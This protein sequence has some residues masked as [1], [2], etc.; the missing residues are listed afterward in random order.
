MRCGG[1]FVRITAH[2]ARPNILVYRMVGRMATPA[3][4]VRWEMGCQKPRRL[5]NPVSL[6]PVISINFSRLLT[7]RTISIARLARWRRAANSDTSASFAAPS[8]GGAVS[9]TRKVLPSR[10]ISSRPARGVTRTA[11]RSRDG[12]SADV[13]Q[14]FIL[15]QLYQFA[16]SAERIRPS[17]C[18][19]TH[20]LKMSAT[21]RLRSTIMK[22]ARGIRR[23]I[24]WRM[25]AVSLSKK[26]EMRP[27][28]LSGGM[29]MNAVIQD[30]MTLIQMQRIGRRKKSSMRP[31]RENAMTIR[32]YL[33]PLRP[34][35]HLTH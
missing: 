4:L 7:P 8:T 5:Q 34:L 15:Y 30:R 25:G 32:S 21:V 24:G 10:V 18:T 3:G 9:F 23:A 19:S 17:N 12:F 31:R 27:N 26:R 6:R 33:T 14:D 2:T 11:M 1:A 16:G 29:G 13:S 28:R 35:V 22:P 20:Q